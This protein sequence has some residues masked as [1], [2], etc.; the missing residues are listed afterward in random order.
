MIHRSTAHNAIALGEQEFN[1]V[2]TTFDHAT[3]DRLARRGRLACVYTT[4]DI[5]AT[6]G[7]YEELRKTVPSLPLVFLD[8]ACTHAFCVFPEE[9]DRMA[10][11]VVPLIWAVAGT[12]D[13]S[14]SDARGHQGSSRCC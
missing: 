7:Q 13:D 4:N 6:E 3:L 10:E 5:W 14:G 11:A 2:P 9:C 12:A 1:E 8:G